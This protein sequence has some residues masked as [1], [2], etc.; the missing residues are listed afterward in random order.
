MKE[1]KD[2][3]TSTVNLFQQQ[4]KNADAKLALAMFAGLSGAMIAGYEGEVKTIDWMEVGGA[5]VPKLAADQIVDIAGEPVV[6]A[7]AGEKPWAVTIQFVDGR[8]MTL[9]LLLQGQEKSTILF[10]GQ[11][12][13]TKVIDLKLEDVANKLIGKRFKCLSFFRNEANE[14][15]RYNAAGEIISKRPANCYTFAETTV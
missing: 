10:K 13:A 12:D 3:D 7:K 6:I 4:T 2:I 5:N 9:G 1:R 11:T 15:I 8:T 14:I